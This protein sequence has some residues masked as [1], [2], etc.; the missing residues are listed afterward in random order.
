MC[1]CVDWNTLEID[2]CPLY[3]RDMTLI[4]CKWGPCGY[5]WPLIDL[6]GKWDFLRDGLWNAH[7]LLHQG[8][9]WATK[10]CRIYWHIKLWLLSFQ[11]LKQFN[12]EISTG[13]YFCSGFPVD[14]NEGSTS[15]LLFVLLHA[16]WRLGDQE[17]LCTH[18]LNSQQKMMLTLFN[19]LFHNRK[20]K[21]VKFPFFFW[22]E[23]ILFV[24]G[25]LWPD[26]HCLPQT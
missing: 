26:Q 20:E 19:S 7:H 3:H 17:D 24:Q 10:I 18:Y 21:Q 1:A 14:E 4:E 5:R 2:C 15:S 22:K 12:V 8:L 13:L 25:F 23:Q 16:G 11:I 6:R 9:T